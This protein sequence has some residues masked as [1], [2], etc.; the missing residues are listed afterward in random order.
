MWSADRDGDVE[1][2]DETTDILKSLKERGID[3]LQGIQN[4]F[5]AQH[6]GLR[7]ALTLTHDITLRR[8]GA[9]IGTIP[10]MLNTAIQNIGYNPSKN[11]FKPALTR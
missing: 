9:P 5:E 11:S 7:A 6:G 10:M 1:G 8:L 3:I 2:D 4:H